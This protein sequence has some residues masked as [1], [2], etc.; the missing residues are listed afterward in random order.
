M[1][2]GTPD[3]FGWA[4]PDPYPAKGKTFEEARDAKR[5]GAQCRRVYDA[6]KDAQWRGLGDIASLTGDP[7]ASISARLR[8]L[9]RFGFV[10]ERVFVANGLHHYR[11]YWP[12][13][14]EE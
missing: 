11:M 2:A 10:V 7:E 6:M 12:R 1:V 9:R 13:G 8:D 14:V 5:L 4:P 3:L